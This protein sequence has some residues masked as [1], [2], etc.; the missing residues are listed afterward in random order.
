MVVT[1]AYKLY[2]DAGRVRDSASREH[3]LK[4]VHGYA[5]V[6]PGLERG[7]VGAQAGERRKLS[8]GPEEAFGE[9]DPDAVL[10]IDGADFPG[11]ERAQPGDEIVATGPDGTECAYRIVAV[12]DGDIVADRNHPLAG[13][14][15]RF[16]IEVLA[17][18]PAHEQEIAAAQDDMDER[19]VYANTIV[20]QSEPDEDAASASEPPGYLGGGSPTPP[21]G[22]GLVQLRKKPKTDS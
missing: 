8:L 7:I 2:D 3:P 22:G 6:V 21:P 9:R 18:R 10:E 20:Y 19:I 12:R 5:Q 16:E 4:F 11:G 1:L 15:V 17:V 13:Q 14:R